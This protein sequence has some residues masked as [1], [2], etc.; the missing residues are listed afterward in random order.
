MS[1]NRTFN[2]DHI[3][4]FSLPTLSPNSPHTS[5]TL[6]PHSPRTLP[7]LS[8]HFPHTLPTLSPHSPHT[9]RT[10]HPHSPHTLYTIS[11]TLSP[12]LSPHSLNTIHTLSPHSPHTPATLSPH[13]SNT[14]P[15]LS[16]SLIAGT[17][18]TTLRLVTC[19]LKQLTGTLG[20]QRTPSTRPPG[21]L[22]SAGG[23][24]G[25][26]RSWSR[27]KT[28]WNSSRGMLGKVEVPRGRERRLV[29]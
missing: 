6:S 11:P 15:T 4:S 3:R 16:L 9:L 27:G 18:I 25:R 23:W 20:Q 17:P 1:L 2:V 28:N 24:T 13:S 8:S 29:R 26:E 22:R 5:H 21:G 19:L 14:L 12:T 7:T 10:L